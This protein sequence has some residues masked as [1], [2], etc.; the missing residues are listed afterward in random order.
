MQGAFAV[1]AAFDAADAGVDPA[2]ASQQT[3]FTIRGIRLALDA[4]T[5][6][7]GAPGETLR[8]RGGPEGL[9]VENQGDDA[10]SVSA[11]L[12][13]PAPWLHGAWNFSLGPRESETLAL[14]LIIPD[15]PGATSFPATLHASLVNRTAREVN[16]S[17]TLDILDEAPPTIA[18][19]AIAPGKLGVTS[20]L[21]ATVTDPIG[22]GPVTL[23]VTDPTG[24]RLAYGMASQGGGRYVANVTP[25]MAGAYTLQVQARDVADPPRETL[26]DNLTWTVA[27]RPFAGMAPLGFGEGS[28]VS[29]RT[30]HFGE[31]VEASVASARADIGQGAFPLGFPPDVQLPSQDGPYKVT[32]TSTSLDGQRMTQTWNVTLR[33]VPPRLANATGARLSDG[34]VEVHVDADPGANL[35]LRFQTDAGPVDYPFT[36]SGSASAASLSVTPPA[37]WSGVSVLATDKAGNHASV[38]VAMAKQKVPMPGAGVV[39]AVF[40]GLALALRRRAAGKT[41][42]GEDGKQGRRDEPGK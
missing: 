8:F 25:S 7:S 11:W 41:G 10:E 17:L 3:T 24:A 32:I 14:D 9:T 37:A 15:A 30:L 39:L 27:G 21:G 36:R 28:F 18:W 13:S 34:R 16:A 23:L 6:V 31:A 1:R 12:D 4:P 38:E 35:T 42:R 40:A 33:T 26:G 29:G 2:L 19:G 20:Q 5:R 22:V